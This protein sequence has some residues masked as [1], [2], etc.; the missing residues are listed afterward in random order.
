MNYSIFRT[1]TAPGVITDG[2]AASSTN[3]YYSAPW[4]GAHSDGHNLHLENTGT[5]TGT[6]TLWR[7]NK[8]DPILSSDAD[9]VQDT[10]FT[11]TNPAGAASKMMD[12]A[13]NSKARWN[14]VKYVNAS[15]TGNIL[16]FVTA[17][18]MT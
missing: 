16:G 18:R 8:K 4:S 10:T 3:T 17:P 14:R 5:L 9:W 1:E 2:V 12:D 7:S 15:G 13:G 11:P 6:Y